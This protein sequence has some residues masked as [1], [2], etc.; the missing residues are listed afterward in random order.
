MRHALAAFVALAALPAAADTRTLTGEAFYRERIALAPEAVL[1]VEAR[2]ADGALA[3]EARV[4]AEGRQV[5]LPFA[6]EAPQ[7]A[8]TLRAALMLGGRAVW[9]SAL[10]PV[11]EGGTGAVPPILLT[12]F[13]ALAF[14]TPYRCGDTVVTV[15][16]DGPNARLRANG[17]TRTLAPEPAASG[18]RF[19]GDGAEFWSKGDRATVTLEGTTLPECLP[20]IPP[21]LFPLTA[22]GNEPFWTLT[23]AEGRATFNPMAG[24]AS[25]DALPEPE[26]L[27][28]ALRFA[29]PS[30]LTVTLAEAIHR[31]TMTG[32]PYPV[33]VTLERDGETLTGG[34]GAPMDL[35]AGPEWRVGT[36]GGEALAEGVEVTFLVLPEG[37]VAGKSAC[38]RYMGS[39]AISGEG[40]A[41]GPLA[42]TMM[43]CPDPLMTVERRWLD[44]LAAVSR[45]DIAADGALILY[46]GDAEA[47]RLVR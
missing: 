18:A 16:F 29:L 12:R 4:A 42:G 27:P 6:V 32:M 9:A 19:A 8:L 31:D 37:R 3:A 43:A 24:T 2:T 11:A 5:P 1:V 46:T 47:A 39:L 21:G 33:T 45:F 22:R 35:L 17:V 41:F 34:G 7:A 13:E 15:G 30:G 40:L 44:T 10:V 38:N 14:A 23:L 25:E 28:D 26:V 20:A 36:L